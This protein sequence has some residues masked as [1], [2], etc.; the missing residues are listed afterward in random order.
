MNT[1]IKTISINGKNYVEADSIQPQHN[2]DIKIVVLQR[3]WVMVGKME[4]IGSD[5]KL[6]NASVIRS[7]GTT[8]GLG[9]IAGN[10]PTSNT[11]L[12]KCNGLVEF[13]SLT[14][15]A[16]ICVNQDKWKSYL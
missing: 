5:V 14:V 11:K 13:D 6:H 3:G 4:K 7:W 1:E 16:S 12:D 9:E 2:G 10:G 8:K 15:V